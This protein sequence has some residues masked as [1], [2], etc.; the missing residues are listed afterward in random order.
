MCTKY[1]CVYIRGGMRSWTNCFFLLACLFFWEKQKMWR[2]SA[3][4]SHSLRW[5]S[6]TA[7]W[8]F[9]TKLLHYFFLSNNKS[10]LH[11]LRL[12]TRLSA[13][14]NVYACVLAHYV[15]HVNES[16]L[17]CEWFK[18]WW[19]CMSHASRINSSR[20]TYECVP[21]R[22]GISYVTHGMSHASY[23]RIGH[24]TPLTLM[25]IHV[26]VTWMSLVTYMHASW[27]HDVT[28]LNKSCHT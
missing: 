9:Q 28:H 20:R 6:K 24:V 23:M 25:L 8:E 10:N 15:A 27:M 26:T 12:V 16:C 3:N 4:H 11:Q 13:S 17:Q 19:I 18:S 5:E 7:P 14:C 2:Q 22:I 1:T 21:S